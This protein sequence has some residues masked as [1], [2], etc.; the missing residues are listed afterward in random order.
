MHVT[1][2]S[3]LSEPLGAAIRNP[4]APPVAHDPVE[5]GI[6][7]EIRTLVLVEGDSDAGAVRALAAI[8][9]CDL[10]LRHIRIWSAGGVTNF[11]QSLAGFVRTH[12]NAEFC[13]MYD[14]AEERHVRRA[15]A[16]A[17]VPIAAHQ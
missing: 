6:I 15:L 4:S 13:G 12:P 1:E 16:S 10:A 14:V 8:L 7:V 2:F 17:S 3:V 9:D 5:P 11:S